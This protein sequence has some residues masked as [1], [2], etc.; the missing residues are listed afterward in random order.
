VQKACELLTDADL[1]PADIAEFLGFCSISYFY[2]VFK[3]IIGM[4]PA[5]FKA[6]GLLNKQD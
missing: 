2:R 4:T 6:Q 3:D 5:E 1:N